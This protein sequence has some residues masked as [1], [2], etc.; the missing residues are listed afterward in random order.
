MPSDRLT[1]G[2]RSV[3]LYDARSFGRETILIQKNHLPSP[4]Y[5]TYVLRNTAEPLAARYIRWQQAPSGARRMLQ[6][7]I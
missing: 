7:K 6:K 5:H 2:A 3:R 1:N 4:A